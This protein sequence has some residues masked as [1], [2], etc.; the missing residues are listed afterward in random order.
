MACLSELKRRT[1]SVSSSTSLSSNHATEDPGANQPLLV[2]EE[3]PPGPSINE[4]LQNSVAAHSSAENPS[5][6]N[7]HIASSSTTAQPQKNPLQT[8]LNED[9]IQPSSPTSDT[10][11]NQVSTR[12]NST[13]A[14]FTESSLHRADRVPDSTTSP[15][16]ASISSDGTQS[17][18]PE[19]SPSSPSSSGAPHS[20]RRQLS[21]NSTH[22][23]SPSNEGNVASAIYVMTNCPFYFLVFCGKFWKLL[24]LFKTF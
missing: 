21:G 9:D 23:T 24:E 1:C 8:P 13:G 14:P 7:D 22:G 6:N 4:S 2:S 3:L 11:P 10:F 20:S 15:T 19:S 5:H 18:F 17:T 16:R 12:S